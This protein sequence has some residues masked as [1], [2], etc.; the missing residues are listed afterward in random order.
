VWRRS[1]DGFVAIV[2]SASVDDVQL[3][4]INDGRV[5]D[6]AVRREWG[7]RLRSSRAI[8]DWDV[9]KQHVLGWIDGADD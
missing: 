7:L 4:P 9:V 8:L 1:A 6:E 2:D 3:R 5:M